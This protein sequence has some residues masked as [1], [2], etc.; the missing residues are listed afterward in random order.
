TAVGFNA[1]VTAAFPVQR[2]ER[3]IGGHLRRSES[4]RSHARTH[5]RLSP[6]DTETTGIADGSSVE[7]NGTRAAISGSDENPSRR[8]FAIRNRMRNERGIGPGSGLAIAA[9]GGK[10]H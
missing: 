7:R 4:R 5:Q 9:S 1:P 6:R 2:P 10:R 8:S 3:G